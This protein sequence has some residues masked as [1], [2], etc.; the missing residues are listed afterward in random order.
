[1]LSEQPKKKK[2]LVVDDDDAIRSM[3]ERVLRREQFE[4]ESARDGFEAI[5]KLARNDYGTV[6][7][8]LMMPRVDGHGVLRF[9]ETE[10][11][12]EKPWVIV[13][14][15]NMQGASE[16]AEAKP[17]FRVLP[18]PFDIRQLISHVKECGQLADA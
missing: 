9:L 7:L 13:M 1:L 6:L 4:V 16:T 14:T 17:V 5:E 11:P 3:V 8:D 12:A 2:V 18:K 15:A 10:R